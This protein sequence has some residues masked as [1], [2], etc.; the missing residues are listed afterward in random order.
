MYTLLIRHG[1]RSWNWLRHTLCMQEAEAPIRLHG[2]TCLCQSHLLVDA[3]FNVLAHLFRQLETSY[4][5]NT[6]NNLAFEVT[7]SFHA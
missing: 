1:L 7:D 5:A 6:T 4:F 3:K 2:F